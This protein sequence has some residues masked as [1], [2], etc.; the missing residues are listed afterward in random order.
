MAKSESVAAA[1]ISKNEPASSA[2]D[3]SPARSGMN[4]VSGWPTDAE[5]TPPASP[6]PHARP[7]ADAFTDE[8]DDV[9][10]VIHEL[11][12]QLDRY[13]GV[14]ETLERELRESNEQAAAGRQRVQELEWQVVTLQTRVDALEQVR[15]E[16]ALLE[17]ELADANARSQRVTEQFAQAQQE[18]ARISGELKASGKQLEELWTVRKERDGLRND[19]KAIRTRAEQL[20]GA[21]RELQQERIASQAKIEETKTALEEARQARHQAELKLRAAEDLAEE[22]RKANEATERRLETTQAENRT[23]ATQF[24]HLEREKTRLIEQQQFYECELASLRNTNR[25]AETALNNIKKAFSEVRAALSETRTRARRRATDTW[26]RTPAL[27][28]RGIPGQ[29]AA[30]P[31][32]LP[33]GAGVATETQDANTIHT[34]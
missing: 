30:I 33:D 32:A 14:R 23:L 24:T 34:S 13:E 21:V 25:N 22:L 8:R 29:D 3:A 16:I 18:N 11:E 9:L 6:R 5:P 26:P 17:E 2:S 1:R 31:D 27:S 7:G 4:G 28:L 15:Q 19:I 12:D 10:T 20:D